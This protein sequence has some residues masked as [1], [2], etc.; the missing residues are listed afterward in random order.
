MPQELEPLIRERAYRLWEEAGRPE[1]RAI[2]HWQEAERQIL[3]EVRAGWQPEGPD[4]VATAGEHV[5]AD[6]VRNPEPIP[7]EDDLE[8]PASTGPEQLPAGIA[9]TGEPDAPPVDETVVRPSGAA[10]R[11]LRKRPGNSTLEP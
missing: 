3:A 5:A 2:D 9:P 11:G 8:Y 10:R 6:P 7:P 4:E 1:D